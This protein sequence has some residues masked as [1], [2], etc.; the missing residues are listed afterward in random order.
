MASVE[1]EEQVHAF[2]ISSPAVSPARPARNGQ[3]RRWCG[4]F[5]WRTTPG[6]TGAPTTFQWNGGTTVTAG[7]GA[8]GAGQVPSIP[9]ISTGGAG[10]AGSNGTINGAG[11]PGTPGLLISGYVGSSGNGGSTVYGGGGVGGT[12]GYG[13]NAGQAMVQV[14]ADITRPSAGTTR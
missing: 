3:K 13:A 6:T 12:T 7:G 1:A 8:G 4:R 11:E 5:V 9:K 14:V 2:C 10:G